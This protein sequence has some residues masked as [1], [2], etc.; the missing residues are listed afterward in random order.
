MLIRK[1]KH[2]DHDHNNNNSIMKQFTTGSKESE[3]SIMMNEYHNSLLK[4]FITMA[5]CNMKKINSGYQRQVPGF[6]H[7]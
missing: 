5:E 1:K 7:R 2:H 3:S 4:E 6:R